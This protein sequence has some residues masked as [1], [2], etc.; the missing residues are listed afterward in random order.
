[1]YQVLKR[2]NKSRR[3]VPLS[4]SRGRWGA[5]EQAHIFMGR[6]IMFQINIGHFQ[7]ERFSQQL[8]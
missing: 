4:R 6:N 7:A 3:F 1:M 2:Q 5:D 8:R